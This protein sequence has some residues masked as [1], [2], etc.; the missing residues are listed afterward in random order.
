MATSSKEEP[1]RIPLHEEQVELGRR[2]R[3]TGRVTVRTETEESEQL[4]DE[5][6]AREHADIERVPVERQVDAVPE[7]REEGDT[8]IVPVVEEVLVVERRLILKEEVRIRRVRET[9]KHRETVTLR[10]Q[11]AVITRVPVDET[12]ADEGRPNTSGDT[13]G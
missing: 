5:L 3:V 13:N 12:A 10:K 8:I 1:T 11:R 4:I 7:V 6:V 2:L 9:E